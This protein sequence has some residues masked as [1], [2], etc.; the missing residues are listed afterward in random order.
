MPNLR[1]NQQDKGFAAQT[2]C[3]RRKWWV[4]AW[5][6]Y[7]K[8]GFLFPDRVLQGGVFSEGGAILLPPFCGSP[9]P[10]FF[11]QQNEPFRS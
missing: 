11:M 4:C 1:S 2:P 10:F 6:V 5:F 7:Q 3:K 9:G 8:H